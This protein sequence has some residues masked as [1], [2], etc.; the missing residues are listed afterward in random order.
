MATKTIS[1]DLE[2]YR[3]LRSVRRDTESF[4]QTI[5]RIV[6]TPI[7]VEAY[8]ERLRAVSLS[9]EGTLGIEQH[10]RDRHGPS[11]RER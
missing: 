6:P 5:K 8:L 3:R 4:S 11:A 2:A 10:V 1:I 7:D 9:E